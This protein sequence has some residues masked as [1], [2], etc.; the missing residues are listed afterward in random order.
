MTLSAY[1][2]RDVFA[3][4]YPPE[5]DGLLELRA[6]PSKKQVFVV[7][8]DTRTVP[9]FLR[10]KQN[11]YVGVATRQTS[12]DGTAEN[13]QQLTALFVDLDFKDVDEHTAR[14]R[15]TTFPLAPS[16]VVHSGGG[17]H[18]YWLLREPLDV[19]TESARDEVK[20]LLRRLARYLGADTA[21]AE[22]ARV[23]RLPGSVNFKYTPPRPVTV[24]TLDATRRYNPSDFDEL[25]PADV[26][27]AKQQ[28][29]HTSTDGSIPEG[30]RNA[31][32]TSLAG[33][34]RRP[35][36]S[37]EAILAALRVENTTRCRPPLPDDDVQTI[38]RS[39][40]KYEPD[41]DGDG[42]AEGGKRESQASV[43]V[44][45][46][47]D[48]GAT[49]FHTKAGD[50][51]L[52]VPVNGHH[53]NHPL[54]ARAAKDYAARLY[55]RETEKAPSSNGLN[56]A[57]ATM[58]GVARFD[59][60]E[61]ETHVRIAAVG[62]DRIYLDLGDADWRAVEVTASG[63]RIIT[64]PPVRFRRPRGVLPIPAPVQGGSISDLR[65]FLNVGD[66]DFL[67]VVAFLLMALRG[68]GPYPIAS[69]VA[70]QGAAKTTT[71]RVL[72]RLIDPNESDVRRPPRDIQDL[73]VAATNGHV[74]AFDNL[75]RLSDDLSD[76]LAVLSTGGGFSARQLYT[77]GEEHIFSAQKPIILNGIAHVVT[78]GDLA[79]R[80]LSLTLPAIPES[81]RRDERTFWRAF[82][83]A[84][85]TML[86][87]LLDAVVMA[88]R[89]VGSITLPVKPR[90]ADF[91]TWVSAAEPACPWDEG[92]FLR[93]YT[94]NR[95]GAIEAQ[96]E[97]DVVADCARKL[98]PWK[99]TATDLLAEL[100]KVTD[101][102][103]T[104]RK[105]WP[106][107]TARKVA[108][109]LRR[110]AP[111]LRQT[112]L[113]VNFLKDTSSKRSRYIDLS[114]AP[115][116]EREGQSA[117]DASDASGPPYSQ[118][119]S[120]DAP[121]THASDPRTH[122]SEPPTPPDESD[123]PSDASRTHSSDENP[124]RYG[125]SDAPDAPD[126]HEPPLSY[127]DDIWEDIA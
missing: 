28:T 84:Q 48:G 125:R 30:K 2:F 69:F 89:R 61:H 54:R 68:R 76:S 17:L 3:A 22:V 106:Y 115:K 56:D 23:L 127:P 94:A 124:N 35:G 121:R 6:L 50:A 107:T 52:R 55:F 15:L 116:Q 100:T 49:L 126:A 53:E 38:A 31:H 101:E 96:L 27:D 119:K 57:L 18:G 83:D 117:S 37:P 91:A 40:G 93:A 122:S 77:D 26:K 66:D 42:D 102:T 33:S 36:M 118:A 59:G 8:G 75:S 34:M 72:R 78:R 46:V 74:I 123:A 114:L 81:R 88:L 1:S 21:C 29:T 62:D 51:Y 60:E 95:Q 105:D 58:S 16:I 71:A 111:A 86:G 63:W 10:L 64:N 104:K 12:K 112:G 70:E 4:L 79:D 67:L 32:L 5:V 44:R 109:A 20:T 65:P 90:M 99:G 24:E 92:A 110:V 14:T 19:S 43:I 82:E 97:D 7:R 47:L 85:P 9:A 41:G 11:L 108:D 25:L 73:M 103:L 13:C 87:A 120:S 98:A 39:V 45:L 113:H 80:A